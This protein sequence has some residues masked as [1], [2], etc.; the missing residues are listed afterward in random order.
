MN[1]SVGRGDT[2]WSV[3]SSVAGLCYMGEAAVLLNPISQRISTFPSKFPSES[4][5]HSA[6]CL[7]TYYLGYCLSS[8][9]PFLIPPCSTPSRVSTRWCQRL[10]LITSPSRT[11]IWKAF[12]LP[13]DISAL[14]FSPKPLSSLIISNVP[15]WSQCSYKSRISSILPHLLVSFHSPQVKVPAWPPSTPL[16]I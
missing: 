16:S 7:V 2:I 15:T 6:Q 12:T 4:S 1:F 3:T 8:Y 11:V 5:N 10:A 13:T 9:I 14:L